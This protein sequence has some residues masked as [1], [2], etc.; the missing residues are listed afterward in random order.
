MRRHPTDVVSLVFGLFFLGVAALWGPVGPGA[1][2]G[3]G[4]R[5]PLLLIGAGMAGLLVSL[6]GWRD[7]RQ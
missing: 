1:F 4:L 7:G 6:R 3:P 2:D 5:L